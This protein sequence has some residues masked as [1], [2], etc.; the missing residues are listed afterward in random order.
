MRIAYRLAIGFG[1]L[2]A[3]PVWGQGHGSVAEQYLFAMANAERAQRGLPVLRWEPALYSAAAGHAG[4]MAARQNISHE[5]EGEG[6]V[7]ERAQ[8]A[9]AKFSII[10]ENVAEAGTAVRIHDAWMHSPGHRENLL[11]PRVD[12]VGIS[13]VRRNGQLYA[14]EDFERAVLS[15]TL[16]QQEDLVGGLVANAARLHVEASPE[17]RQTCALETGYAGARRPGF[18]IRYTAAE[19]G[20]LP[21]ALKTRLG[22]GGYSEAA[23]GA[24][25]TPGRQTFT[26]YS[27]AV[28]L[29]R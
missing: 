9:G 26:S 14:V 12:A 27:L 1:M 7:A 19:L 10:S 20:T 25:R 16:E 28:M 21:V 11:D 24:C 29:F 22:S 8:A 4:R 3:L 13:V 6:D 17:A 2:F 5:Y 23:V 15:L 18:V